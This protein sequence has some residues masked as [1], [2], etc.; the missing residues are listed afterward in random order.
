MIE[1]GVT[2]GNG[3]TIQRFLSADLRRANGPAV[4]TFQCQ[5]CGD[6]LIATELQ[7]HRAGWLT[8]IEIRLEGNKAIRGHVCPGCRTQATE[9]GTALAF[10]YLTPERRVPFVQSPKIS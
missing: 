9:S 10:E 4:E 8:N 6:I 3:V 7:A 5:D 1:R 2:E